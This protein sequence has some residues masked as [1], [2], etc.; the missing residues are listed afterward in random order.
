MTIVRAY[1]TSL[2]LYP[3]RFR[4]EYGDDM[5]ALFEEQLRDEHA[6][7]VLGRTALDLAL[8]VPSRHLEAHMHRTSTTAL[9]VTFM[10]LAAGLTALGGPLGLL[11]AIGMLVLAA[12]TWRRSRPV[13]ASADGSWWKLVLGGLALLALLVV[14][15]TA[16]GELPEGGWFVAMATLL[17][18]FALI[19]TGIGLGI[20][21]RFGTSA[22]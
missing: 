4:A 11:G 5:V 7:R 6:A 22:P 17:A 14:V 9:V 20:A 21:G 13:A 16:T 3:R 19:G 15:T 1:R 2:R 18:S 8:T 12:L 10:A